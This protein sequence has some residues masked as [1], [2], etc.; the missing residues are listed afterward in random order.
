MDTQLIITLSVTVSIG[1]L[2]LGLYYW[3]NQD[4]ATGQRLKSVVK[5][6]PR[7]RDNARSNTFGMYQLLVPKVAEAL[8]PRNVIEQQQLKLKM[9]RAGFSGNYAAELFLCSK[10]TLLIA[11]GL[12]GAI[13]GCAW[14]GFHQPSLMCTVLAACLF[15]YLPDLVLNWL[16]KRRQEQIFLALPN[17]IDLLIVA[18]EVGQGLD[19]AMRRV[20]KELERNS[21]ALCNELSLYNLQLQMGRS[22]SEALHDLGMRSGV[23]DMNSFAAVMIQADRFGASVAKTMRQLSESARRKRRQMAEERAQ[24]TAVKLIFPLVLFIFPGIFAVL[25]GPAMI[26]LMRD[27]SGMR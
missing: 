15:F 8:K 12:V 17:A 14:F 20:A 7:D 2:I 5:R 10:I 6:D 25:V 21:R 19:A 1:C 3:R 4:R 16:T 23:P 22:R 27:L 9:A 24:K 18:I 11:G 26:L 13:G